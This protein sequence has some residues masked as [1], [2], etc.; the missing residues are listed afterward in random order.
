MNIGLIIYGTLDQVSGGY[1]YD[2]MLMDHLRNHGAAI[3]IFSLLPGTYW[4]HLTDNVSATLPRALQAKGLDLL[5]QDELNHLS[6]FYMNRRVRKTLKCPLIGIVHHLRSS[7]ARPAWQNGFY[8]QTEKLYLETLDGFICNSETTRAAVKGVLG[9]DLPSVVAHPGG[10]HLACSL[11]AEKIARRCREAGPLRILFMGN[12]IP[13]KGLHTLLAALGRL[14][15]ESWQLTVAGSLS[16]DRR[17]VK[18]IK[19][20][21]SQTGI[22]ERALLLDAVPSRRLVELMESHHCLA[23]PSFYEG[24]GIAYLEAMGFGE[25]VIASTA[26]AIPEIIDNGKEGF[27]VPPGDVAGLAKSIA[28]LIGDRDL[29]TA[30]SAAALKRSRE[31]PT[32]ADS[33]A[34]AQDFLKEMI[35]LKIAG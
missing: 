9:R 30:M 19:R 3:K 5:L 33:M 12:V 6:L 20:L 35:G 10:D 23:I 2:R 21:I 1:L 26:G 27:L 15:K 25:T 8:R 28:R 22:G 17:Y 34:R 32:W 4:R 7:E 29:L 18:R 31:H 24:F 16:A 14:S 11:P 13:R